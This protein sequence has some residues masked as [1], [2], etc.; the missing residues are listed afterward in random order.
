MSF[1]RP[2]GACRQ[3]R[4]GRDGVAA[5]TRRPGRF[6]RSGAARDWLAG[7][8]VIERLEHRCPSNALRADAGG[9]DAGGMALQQPTQ[10]PARSSRSGAARDWLAGQV[11]ILGPVPRICC[12]REKA[13]DG[14]ISE[15][16]ASAPVAGAA[17]DPRARPKDDAN[18]IE[19]PGHRCPSNALRADA[20]GGDVGGMA[21]RFSRAGAARDWLAGQV[22][23]L[24]P[25][26]RICCG[27]EKA[28]E[29]EISE[30]AASSPVAGAAADPRA[31]P[32][33][34][35]NAIGR[36]GHRSPANARRA[37]ARGEGMNA[38]MA[39][40][41][42]PPSPSRLACHLSPC[43]G[44]RNRGLEK[45]PSFDIGASSPPG[46]GR[47]GSGEDRDRGGALRSGGGAG[48]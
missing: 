18:V 27:R 25:D 14:E 22:V 8:V 40:S 33:D 20:G 15:T 39:A 16:A 11:V 28:R 36:D 47:G 32:E 12:G 34:D 6:S 5:T 48:R 42:R 9:G 44:E 45:S 29:G 2:A 38:M 37:E 31:R 10:R 41:H 4:R 46:R 19:R 30:T 1:E 3:S 23:I 43:R 21:A 35:A 17:T 24:G 13:R 26:P 7:Q